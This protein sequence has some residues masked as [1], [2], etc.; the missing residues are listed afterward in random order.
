MYEDMKTK[1]TFTYRLV[2]VSIPLKVTSL[3]TERGSFLGTTASE[4]CELL[5]ET[6]IPLSSLYLVFSVAPPENVRKGLQEFT[7]R[8][9]C[10]HIYVTR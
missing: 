2:K 10:S 1:S 5:E 8:I 3:A 6:N 9:V 7:L 4:R